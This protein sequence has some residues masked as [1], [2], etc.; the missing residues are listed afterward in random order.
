MSSSDWNN[1]LNEGKRAVAIVRKGLINRGINAGESRITEFGTDEDVPIYSK[2]NQR[3]L[4]WISV[5]SVSSQ[6]KNPRILP[7]GYQGWMCGEV[8]SKQWVNPP[9]AIIWYCL[10]NGIAWG[11]IPPSRLSKGWVIFPDRWRKIVDKRK[12]KYLDYTVYLYPSWLVLPDKIIT[13]E[14]IIDHIINLANQP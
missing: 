7:V 8:E 14:E 11:A 1:L 2:N 3:Q 5:K 4:F 12:T 13:K 6:V 9:S 10:E